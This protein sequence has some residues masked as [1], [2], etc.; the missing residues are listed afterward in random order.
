MLV[1]DINSYIPDE[2]VAGKNADRTFTWAILV[3]LAED[4]VVAL[5]NDVREQRA[6]RR[7]A[8]DDVPRTIQIAP[9][10]MAS[11]LQGDF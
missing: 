10:W 3:H 7:A 6:S 8:A 4:F 5:L 2:W 1:P 9:E 11:L